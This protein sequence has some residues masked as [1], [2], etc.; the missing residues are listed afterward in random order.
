MRWVFKEA[1]DQGTQQ[2]LSQEL[3]ISPLLSGL[4]VQRGITTFEDARE[5]FR[6]SL[7][8]LHD[9]FLMAG[10]QAATNRLVQAIEKEEKILI[11]GDYDVDGT[12]SVA[13][14]YSFLKDFHPHI[15][16]YIPDRYT[17]GYGIS[18]QGV[19]WAAEH[20]FNLIIALDCGI[21][22]IEKVK[23]ATSL[24]VDFIICDHHR[25]GDTWPDAVAVLDPKRPD[26]NYPYKELSGCGVGLKL[27]QALSSQLDIPAARWESLLDLA[28]I[29]ICADIVPVTG[30]NRVLCHFG[31]KLL[32]AS[33]RPGIRALLEL[34]QLNKTI[35]VN[36]VVFVIAPRINAAGRMESGRKAVEL[37]ITEDIQAAMEPGTRIHTHNTE[38]VQV[39]RAMTRE[40]LDMISREA[41][42]IQRK[43]TV[44]FNPEWHKGVIGIV[45][46][47]LIET[48]YRPTILL[49]ESNGKATGSAR[50]V[51]GFDVYEAIE[52][53]SDLL[54]QFGG[55][56][57][58]AG[59]T[60]KLENVEA[61]TARFEEVVSSRIDLTLLIPQIEVDA[62]I[63][64]PDITPKMYGILE[65]FAPFGPGNMAPVFVTRNVLDRGYAKRVGKEQTHLK[66]DLHQALHPTVRFPAIGFGQ[67]DAID[68]LRQG[69]PVDVCYT[70]DENEWNGKTSLQ[71]VLKDVKVSGTRKS[72][73]T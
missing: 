58:A 5:F 15:D 24:G 19:R 49:T 59:L 31:L 25:P 40:A 38:R 50:S 46:S 51:K 73:A 71:L 33:T 2:R 47:R 26:C 45:A 66:C 65:Q 4:L 30:E 72:I 61:F 37:L 56:M 62:E 34:N 17:E 6:P 10:M 68:W 43:T 28:A 27:M 55:H 52:A 41:N 7:E 16:Y 63:D 39:D 23:L 9:P 69:V 60:L 36:E 12:T 32:N 44:L 8:H 22:A 35:T 64:F 14:V 29:S 11:Y 1:A 42:L 54:E 70:V 48:Y 3:N 13:L 21:K 53:C 18:E 67:G 57:Y 20:N